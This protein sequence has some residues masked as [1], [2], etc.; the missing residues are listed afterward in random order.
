MAIHVGSHQATFTVLDRSNSGP[1]AR[2]GFDAA[3]HVTR[4]TDFGGVATDYVRDAQGR[5][6]SEIEA[7]RRSASKP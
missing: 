1:T 7:M 3:G 5:A 6:T 2:R 4:A